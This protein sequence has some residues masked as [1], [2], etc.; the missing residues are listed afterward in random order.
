VTK[1]RTIWQGGI[2]LVLKSAI[3]KSSPTGLPK[4]GSADV[5]VGARRL[6][7]RT[8]WSAHRCAL[9]DA[10]PERGG[11]SVG[12][13]S[14]TRRGES[15]RDATD[16]VR[17]HGGVAAT[18]PAPQAGAQGRS[19]EWVLHQLRSRARKQGT[20]CGGAALCRLRQPPRLVAEGGRELAAR[21]TSAFSSSENGRARHSRY[22][23]YLRAWRNRA[24][25]GA[26]Q[27]KRK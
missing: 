13:A 7:T 27:R 16:P 26:R 24:T 6:C 10:S 21:C 12:R 22:P 20:T 1:R 23:R 15:G 19:Q 11:H 3:S 18:R 2:W 25:I 8:T 14:L 5:R 9:A 17:R 4:H